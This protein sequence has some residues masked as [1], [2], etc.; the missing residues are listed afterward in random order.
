MKVVFVCSVREGGRPHVAGLEGG[1]RCVA[2]IVVV[3]PEVSQ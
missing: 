3:Q 1:R 2:T